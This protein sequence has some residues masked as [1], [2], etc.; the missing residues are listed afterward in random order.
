MKKIHQ[1]DIHNAFIHGDLQEEVY[2]TSPCFFQ[3]GMKKRFANFKNLCTSLN[4][5]LGAGLQ[6]WLVLLNTVIFVSPIL[7]TLYSYILPDLFS[8]CLSLC[9]WFA[10]HRKWP[11]ISSK[12]QSSFEHMLAYE[13]YSPNEIFPWY[14]SCSN[15]T[16]NLS[17]LA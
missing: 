12:I 2:E 5:L 4:R 10:H 15:S 17:L 13:R 16:R 8:L 14:R 7:I 11:C 9:G 3:K 1:M 6:N